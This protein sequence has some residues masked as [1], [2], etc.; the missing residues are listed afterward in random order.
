MG[1]TKKP[2]PVKKPKDFLMWVGAQHYPT[3][4]VLV[5]ALSRFVMW[6][7]DPDEC[8]RRHHCC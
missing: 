6:G 2:E 7:R 8:T 4:P 5:F 3:N 1:E